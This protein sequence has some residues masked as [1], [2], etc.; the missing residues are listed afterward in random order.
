MNIP[1]SVRRQAEEADRLMQQISARQTEPHT[2]ELE[3]EPQPEPEPPPKEEVTESSPKSAKDEVA[4]WEQRYR[5]LQGKYDAEVGRVHREN[6]ELR[7]KLAQLEAQIDQLMKSKQEQEKTPEP[8]VRPEDVENYG[9]EMIDLVERVAR[10]VAAD[11]TKDLERVIKELRDENAELKRSLAG[12]E[13]KTGQTAQE[14]FL[15]RL[16]TLVP[17]WEVLNRD[18][19]FLAWLGQI[20]PFTGVHRQQLLDAAGEALDAQRVAAFFNAYKQGLGRVEPSPTPNPQPP[21]NPQLTRHT[22]PEVARQVQPG[23][24]KAASTPQVP[25]SATRIWS[26]K[27]IEDFY[28]EA[29]LGRYSREEQARIEAEIDL[30]VA[31]GRVR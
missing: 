16:S 30:A 29:S 7:A 12:V 20:D 14:A 19:G 5:T 11:R 4:L 24:S 27:E 25:E 21:P 23:R 26:Q 6:G 13:K 28:R 22:P 8:I 18:P 17:D 2:E 15:Q 1:E 3:P 9:A 10:K 31:Q